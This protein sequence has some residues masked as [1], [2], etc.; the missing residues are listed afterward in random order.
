MVALYPHF[1]VKDL[2]GLMLMALA[3]VSLVA[4]AS[5]LL[6]H[7]DNAIEANSMVTPLHIV[8]EWYFLPLYAILRSIPHKLLGVVAMVSAILVLALLPWLHMRSISAGRYT[9]ISRLLLFSMVLCWLV[10]AWIGGMPVEAPYVLIGQLAS[11]YY[12]GYFLVLQP[13]VDAVERSLVAMLR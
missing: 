1:I 4:Y 10:L 5:E 2:V 13:V 3:M 8:P 7:S 9:P 6:G 12:F 11:C